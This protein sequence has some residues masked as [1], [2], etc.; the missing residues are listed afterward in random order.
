MNTAS[1][2]N[3]IEKGYESLKE[4]GS[5]ILIGVPHFRSKVSI[6]TLAINLGK[7]FIGSKGGKFNPSKD[8]KNFSKIVGLKNLNSKNFIVKKF[9]LEDIN[10]ILDQMRKNNLIGKSVI[11]F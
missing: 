1:N 10:Q 9:K 3:I 11:K 4:K 5:I 8:F 6:N 2:S 7:K